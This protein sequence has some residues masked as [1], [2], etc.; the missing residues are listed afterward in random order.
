MLLNRSSLIK[1]CQSPKGPKSLFLRKQVT[2]VIY[3]QIYV[4]S[5]IVY[6]MCSKYTRNKNK[7]SKDYP[8][9]LKENKKDKDFITFGIEANTN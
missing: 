5:L 8:F 6:E 9:K 2:A 4:G 3:F 7:S 1:E